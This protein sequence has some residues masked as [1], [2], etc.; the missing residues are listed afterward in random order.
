MQGRYFTSTLHA[1][2]LCVMSLFGSELTGDERGQLN[3]GYADHLKTMWEANGSCS[4][5]GYPNPESGVAD[6]NH[7]WGDGSNCSGLPS[8]MDVP[9][10]S[11][12]AARESAAEVLHSLRQ[13][14]GPGAARVRP[15][16]P[17]ACDGDI[18]EPSSYAGWEMLQA[19]LL[20]SALSSEGPP[21]SAPSGGGSW[22]EALWCFNPACTNMEGP[23]S[24]LALKTL[25]CGGGCGV[26]YCSVAC[27]A[28]GWR[29]GH[30]LSCGRLGR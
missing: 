30:K 15:D 17:V 8:P 21:S 28:Q 11:Q 10:A 26:R 4:T 7:T 24:E 13:L 27:Q 9:T 29:D 14:A 18:S 19:E 1:L 6:L 25:A 16:H 2:S 12:A 20:A 23:S 3:A 5:A 22:G